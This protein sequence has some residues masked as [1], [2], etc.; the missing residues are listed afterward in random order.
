MEEFIL[1]VLKEVPLDDLIYTAMTILGQ[2][3]RSALVL[4]MVLGMTLYGLCWLINQV[5]KCVFIWCW[6]RAKKLDINF[7][8]DKSYF[9][10]LKEKK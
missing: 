6:E 9:L 4:L 3:L 8:R 1:N 5:I 7:F 2:G 10:L